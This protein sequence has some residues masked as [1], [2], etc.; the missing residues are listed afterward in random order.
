MAISPNTDFSAGAILTATQQ[1]QFPRGIMAFNTNTSTSAGITSEAL[2]ITSTS[3]TAVAN[4]Y[5]KITYF[6]PDVQVNATTVDYVFARIRLTNIAGAIQQ[7]G[8]AEISAQRSALEI[9]FIKT[10]TAGAV[11]I[12]GTLTAAGGG[13]ILANRAAD[14][15]GYISVEDV[16]PA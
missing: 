8:T 10:F 14:K 12:C 13:T 6:E 2:Q 4:R 5:Y 11:V 1:N 7:S 15:V 9:S 3:F 16:G